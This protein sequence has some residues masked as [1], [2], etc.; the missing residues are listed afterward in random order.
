LA[1]RSLA[2]HVYEMHPQW[3]KLPKTRPQFALSLHHPFTGHPRARQVL[4]SQWFGRDP[5][6]AGETFHCI[7]FGFVAQTIKPA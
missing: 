5:K 3:S 6:I 1:A 4:S 7:R 2:G